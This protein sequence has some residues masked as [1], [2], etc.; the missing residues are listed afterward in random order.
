MQYNLYT[1]ESVKCNQ[2]VRKDRNLNLHSTIQI[3][4]SQNLFS[5]QIGYRVIVQ[6]KLYGR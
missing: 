5:K 3:Q 6:N 2:I 1:S 4:T